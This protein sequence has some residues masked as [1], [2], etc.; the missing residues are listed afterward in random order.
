M[1]R[2]RMVSQMAGGFVVFALGRY[3]CGADEE[4]IKRVGVESSSIAL[5]G[6]GRLGK[7]VEIEF[8]SGAVYRYRDVP[9]EMFNALLAARSKGR[10]FGAH[11][12]GKYRF[13]KIANS[14]P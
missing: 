4:I 12:R 11:I 14:K 7:E 5:V 2:G 9:E 3:A 6:Y 10:F 13:E 8:R 1:T